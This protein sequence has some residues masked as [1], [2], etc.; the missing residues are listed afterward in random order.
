[1]NDAPTLLPMNGVFRCDNLPEPL[2]TVDDPREP[3]GSEWIAELPELTEGWK[4][5]PVCDC[6]RRASLITPY[7]PAI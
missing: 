5:W 7:T 6:G 3:C 4:G 1:M 2:T